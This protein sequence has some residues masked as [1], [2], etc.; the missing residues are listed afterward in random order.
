MKLFLTSNIFNIQKE[1]GKK[2]TINFVNDNSFL[3]KLKECI[4][5]NNKF[6]LIVSDPFDYEKNDEYL[7]LDIQALSSVGINFKE[8]I[9]LDNRNKHQI[10][11][12]LNNSSLIFLSGG[13]TFIQN[14]FFNE[15]NLKKY[16]KEIDACIIGISAGSINSAKVVF[17]SPETTEDLIHPC[18]LDGLNLTEIN[19]EPHFTL[20]NSNKIQM[21]SIIKESYNR[22]IYGLPDKSYIFNNK[23]YGKCYKIYQ[24]NIE[25]ISND[26]EIIDII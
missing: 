23:I 22:V 19:I 12:V 10:D 26:N 14:I 16:I 6:V 20:S 15:I 17:N 3:K 13:N 11:K 7:K 8:Y 5:D 25:I 18:I 9:I 2:K 1:N 4:N 21:D 24:G